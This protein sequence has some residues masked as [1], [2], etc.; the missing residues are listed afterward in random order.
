MDSPS[1]VSM[2]AFAF[3]VVLFT[4]CQQVQVPSSVEAA[5]PAAT[6]RVEQKSAPKQIQNYGPPRVLARLEDPAV[7][8][9]SGIVAS[10]TS[11]GLYWTHNDSGDGPNLYALD[12]QGASHG[13][14]RVRGASA[15][16]WEDIAAGPGP[17][18][19]VSYLYIG[20]IGDN[21][22]KR[23]EVIIYRVKEPTIRSEDASSTKLKPL[24]TEDAEVIHL[25]YPDGAHDAES[26][27]VHPVTGDLYIISKIPFANPTV[28]KARAPLNTNGP[29]T[30]ERIG[31]LDIPSVF[32]G[33][34]TGGD[35]SPD[36][37][38]VALCDYVGGYE[39]VLGD[40]RAPFDQIWKQP[41]QQVD[42][43]RRKQGESIAY[44]LDGRALLATS[45]GAHPPLIETVR[46]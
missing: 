21:E 17:Q 40:A 27:L 26:L 8:E 24:V 37:L 10:R 13:T 9:S 23:D 12:E 44:R 14:W 32:G 7:K 5:R 4:A 45:E 34:I 30:L 41:L 20:D 2:A 46:R 18:S 3:C 42:L 6:P 35:I 28:Y 11:P 29:T 38:R 36:G 43:G 22:G 33:L 25:R 15:R 31:E 39:L 1:I 16:D 19:G